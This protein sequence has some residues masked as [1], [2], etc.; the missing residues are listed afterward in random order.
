MVLHESMIRIHQNIPGYYR[1]DHML[2]FAI[3]MRCTHV[4]LR[5]VLHK[6]IMSDCKITQKSETWFQ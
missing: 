1:A 4:Q 5:L 6:N 2:R 3:Q